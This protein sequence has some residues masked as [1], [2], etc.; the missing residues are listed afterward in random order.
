MARSSFDRPLP[1]MEVKRVARPVEHR[2]DTDNKFDH[3]PR[4]DEI[5]LEM[6]RM[7]MGAAIGRG[8]GG[9]SLKAYGD[10]GMV[11]KV[12]AGE[13]VPDYLAKLYANEDARQRF[14]L[15]LLEG[16]DGVEMETTV[17]IS[18]KGAA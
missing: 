7:N 5:P 4:L 6:A 18:K 10:P 3:D 1:V 11:S 15:A 8:I 2:P 13:K 17:R 12:V 16:I 9:E 14:A